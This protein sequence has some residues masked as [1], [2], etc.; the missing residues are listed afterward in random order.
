MKHG[1]AILCCAILGLVGCGSDPAP[2]K[3]G[4]P[5]S[6]QQSEALRNRLTNTNNGLEVRRWHVQEDATRLVDALG[7][8]ME[9]SAADELATERLQR[10]GFR[11]VR[12]RLDDLEAVLAD[13]GGANV[14]RN[15]WHGQIPEWRPLIER[16]VDRQG[17]AVAIDGRVRRFDRGQMRL[18]IRSWTVQ[19]EDGPAMHLEVLPRHQQP[20]PQN[21]K[22]LLGETGPTGEG[23]GNMAIDL[24]LEDGWAYVLVGESPNQ[25]WPDQQSGVTAI[26]PAAPA[27]ASKTGPMD[28]AGPETD[29]PMTMGEFLL[30]ARSAEARR[31]VVVFVP[32]VP[33]ELFIPSPASDELAIDADQADAREVR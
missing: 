16:P 10:N 8:H 3:E 9:G 31:T 24:R 14:D 22:S 5:L 32:R 29:V 27:R 7:R 2:T 21:L 6:A 28:V 4:E 15:E 23:F 17:Q 25:R 13:L 19:M 20:Q 1:M 12:V 18:M 26:K 30:G 33:K 11:F